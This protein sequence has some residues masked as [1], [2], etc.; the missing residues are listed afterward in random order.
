MKPAWDQLGSAFKESDTVLIGDVDCTASVN[1]DLCSTHGVK[2][3]E[4]L[5]RLDRSLRSCFTS[6]P[7]GVAADNGYS[8]LLPYCLFCL[9]VPTIK[10]YSATDPEG[11]S[12]EGV[13]NISYCSPLLPLIGRKGVADQPYA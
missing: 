12:Y 7:K 6:P 2:G 5:S 1:K 10:Y 13:P 4:F 11:A 8:N 9:T 3:C